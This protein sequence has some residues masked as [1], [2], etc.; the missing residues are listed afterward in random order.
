MRAILLLCLLLGA[1]R[2]RGHSRTGW[3]APGRAGE[4]VVGVI[5]A[6]HLTQMYIFTGGNAANE[7]R[8]CKTAAF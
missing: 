4:T 3:I 8:G 6:E 1:T 2:L 7:W 5:D